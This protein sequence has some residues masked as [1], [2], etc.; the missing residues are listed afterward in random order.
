MAVRLTAAPVM[1]ECDRKTAPNVTAATADLSFGTLELLECLF[2]RP[3]SNSAENNDGRV[4]V[5]VPSCQ[6]IEVRKAA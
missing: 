4:R 6:H 2:D 1:L 5:D 3:R